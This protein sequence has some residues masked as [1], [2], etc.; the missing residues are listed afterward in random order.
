MKG[1]E[2]LKELFKQ[3]KK[4]EFEKWKKKRENEILHQQRVSEG[5]PATL[6]D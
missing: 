4:E 6:G 5:N 2:Y 3:L 1:S